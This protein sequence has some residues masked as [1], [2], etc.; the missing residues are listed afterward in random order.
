MPR[1]AVAVGFR[2]VFKDAEQAYV[3]VETLHIAGGH[4]AGTAVDLHRPVGDPADHFRRDGLAGGHAGER[5][6]AG[7]DAAR[8]F[9]HHCAGYIETPAEIARLLGMTDP[10]LLG[11]V[12][13]TGHLMYGSGTNDPG[14]VRDCLERFAS[15]ICYVHF[16]DCQPEV[17]DMARREGWD[18]FEAVRRGVFCELGKG[19]I[20][21]P[22]IVSWLRGRDYDGWVVV[23]QDVLPGLGSP[24]ESACR[25]REYL[26]SIGV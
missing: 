7:V 3:A 14:A 25:N 17:A 20:D 9:H 8:R 1:D 6:F 15:R 12:L 23:E 19:R 18:Y 4:V 26:R 13:D 24:K 11:L 5:P 16:K 21:F 22:A 2:C 10:D